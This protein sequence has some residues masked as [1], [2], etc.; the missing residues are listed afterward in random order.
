MGEFN[1][2]TKLNVVLVT[3]IQYIV[4]EVNMANCRVDVESLACL[5]NNIGKP[6]GFSADTV[7]KW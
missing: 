6:F 5:K 4:F 2:S 1:D 3:T 7:Y